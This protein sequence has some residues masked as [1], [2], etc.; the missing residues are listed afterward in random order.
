MG[1]RWQITWNI[2]HVFLSSRAMQASSRWTTNRFYIPTRETDY[3][4]TQG[5]Y[6]DNRM[7]WIG[8]CRSVLPDTSSALYPD[9]DKIQSEPICLAL[10]LHCLAPGCYCRVPVDRPSAAA[11]VMET[12]TFLPLMQLFPSILQSAKEPPLAAHY[13]ASRSIS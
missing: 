9:N 11:T 7:P 5:T 2:Q 10:S 6:A 1:R 12:P 13:T 3:Q 8:P 4:G